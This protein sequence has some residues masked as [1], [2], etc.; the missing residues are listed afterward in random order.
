MFL[1]SVWRTVFGAGQYPEAE[2]PQQRRH[3]IFA[4]RCGH[5]RRRPPLPVKLPRVR[6]AVQ[7]W[8]KVARCAVRNQAHVFTLSPPSL[9]RPRPW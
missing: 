1:Q 7:P 2:T 6:R 8:Q 5:L 3:I 4:E 9:R